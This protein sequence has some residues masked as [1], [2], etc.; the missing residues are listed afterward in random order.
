MLTITTA[1]RDFK[2]ALSI[3]TTKLTR[4]ERTEARKL[5]EMF[6]ERLEAELWM[7]EMGIDVPPYGSVEW[8]AY[9]KEWA[10]RGNS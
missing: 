7:D 3:V 9:H 5:A 6:S 2:V 10:E 4:D 8:Q 1:F